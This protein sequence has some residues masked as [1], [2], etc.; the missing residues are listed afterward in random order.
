MHSNLLTYPPDPP[1]HLPREAWEDWYRVAD[2][3]TRAGHT[4]PDY[5]LTVEMY[6]RS[7]YLERQ[8]FNEATAAGLV[9]QVKG[10]NDK[11][12]SKPHP[13]WRVYLNLQA[14]TRRLARSLLLTPQD[15]QPAKGKRTAIRRKGSGGMA[16]RR[17]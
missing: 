6:C 5:L 7:L 12:Q 1:A 10:T 14:Q 11:E 16:V 4:N 13:A 17:T 9:Y 15:N 3:L 8:A 2:E